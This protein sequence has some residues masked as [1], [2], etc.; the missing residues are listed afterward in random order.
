MGRRP[1][2]AVVREA[3]VQDIMTSAVDG[4]AKARGMSGIPKCR[5]RASANRSVRRGRRFAAAGKPLA[6]RCGVK[7]TAVIGVVPIDDAISRLV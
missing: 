2:A 5:Y 1:C 4:L 3:L 6:G 7:R